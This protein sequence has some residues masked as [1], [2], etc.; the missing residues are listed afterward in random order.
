MI[1]KLEQSSDKLTFNIGKFEVKSGEKKEFYI[2]I[3]NTAD[4]TKRFWLQWICDSRLDSNAGYDCTHNDMM[5]N[6]M[7]SR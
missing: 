4:T 6:T 1:K 3:R 7:Q 5:G 2:G